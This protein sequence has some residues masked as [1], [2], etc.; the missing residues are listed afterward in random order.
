MD[1]DLT[2][3]NDPLCWSRRDWRN[4][5]RGPGKVQATYIAAT[6]KRES[7]G[8]HRDRRAAREAIE[9]RHAGGPEPPP[10]AA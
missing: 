7:L 4:Q 8:F 3:P 10:K 5:R 9:A 1:N 2:L 6:G